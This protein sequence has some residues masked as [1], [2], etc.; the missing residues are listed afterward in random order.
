MGKSAICAVPFSAEDIPVIIN[1]TNFMPEYVVDSVI[2]P[3]G[4]GL[5]GKD[6][7]LI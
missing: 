4:L 6:I 5:E 7:G 2:A 1:L 3:G